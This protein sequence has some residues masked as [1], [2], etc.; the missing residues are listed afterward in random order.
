M[1]GWRFELAENINVY[2]VPNVSSKF[3]SNSEVYTS[4]LLESIEEMLIRYS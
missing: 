1:C 3:S 4:E 2:V